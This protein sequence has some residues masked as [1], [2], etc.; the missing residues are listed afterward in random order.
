MKRLIKKHVILL[1]SLA[2]MLMIATSLQAKNKVVVIPLFG[3]KSM[4]NIVTV[5]K[6]GGDFTDL[7]KAIDSITDANGLNQY[8]IVIAPGWYLIEQTIR[9]KAFVS[10]TGS[11]QETTI[12]LGNIGSDSPE[13]SAIIQGASAAELSNFSIYNIGPKT[14]TEFAVG[15]YA[16]NA[17]D[18]SL[19]NVVL[20]ARNGG[21]G[22][23]L[24]RA[25]LNTESSTLKLDNVE[26]YGNGMNASAFSNENTATVHLSN[27]QLRANGQNSVAF[28]NADS[29]TAHLTHVTAIAE[30]LGSIG[31]YNT[32]TSES[33][34]N[35]SKLSGRLMGVG[36]HSSKIRISNTLIEGAITDS[37]STT[38]CR[39]TYDP[40]FADINC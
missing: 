15:L 17:F 35:D 7:Q 12:L 13:N 27:A 23:R 28:F 6:S 37:S 5:A 33:H 24:A 9:M 29:A 21:G 3:S 8:L 34:I 14:S 2:V 31:L 16:E 26:L 25:V 1:L 39:N 19:K 4:N 20:S 22:A 18:L 30:G 36:I 40:N 38:N 10:I 11:G 32:P